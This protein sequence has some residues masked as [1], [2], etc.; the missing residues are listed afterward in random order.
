[1]VRR[2]CQN[3]AVRELRLGREG[4]P[5]PFSAGGPFP[6]KQA[7][8][9]PIAPQFPIRARLAFQEQWVVRGR[10]LG[11]SEGVRVAARDDA[12]FSVQIG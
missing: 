4:T 11:V 3:G 5:E 12:L 10:G 6:V 9:I 8:M 1:M 7:N 2:P